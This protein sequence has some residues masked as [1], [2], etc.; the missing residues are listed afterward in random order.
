[1]VTCGTACCDVMHRNI[2]Y[3]AR[4]ELRKI[5]FFLRRQAVFVF[6]YEIS[7]QPLNTFAPIS[8]GRRGLSLGQV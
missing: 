4:S 8:H 5:L 3:T 7:W 1:M 6:V 2:V